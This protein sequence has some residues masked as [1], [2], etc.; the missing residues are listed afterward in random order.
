[1]PN[2]CPPDDG[3]LMDGLYGDCPVCAAPLHGWAFER[4]GVTVLGLSCSRELAHEPG[5]AETDT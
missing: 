1:M 2:E 3:W 4:D 5:R